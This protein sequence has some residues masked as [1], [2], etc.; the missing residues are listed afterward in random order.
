MTRGRCTFRQRDVTAAIRAAVAA[1]MPVAGVKVSAQGD[2]EVV[3]GFPRAQHSLMPQTAEQD[4]D[5]ELE[6]FEARHGQS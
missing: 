5:R 1:G 2:I 4:L 3:I 6:Q